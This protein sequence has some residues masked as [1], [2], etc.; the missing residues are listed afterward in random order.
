[1]NRKKQKTNI[2]Y[3]DLDGPNMNDI[4]PEEQFQL[5][6][7][8]KPSSTEEAEQVVSKNLSQKPKG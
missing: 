6:P 2:N 7:T 3:D 8:W 5:T 1:M 4:D